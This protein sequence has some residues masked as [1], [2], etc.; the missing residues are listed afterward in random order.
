MKIIKTNKITALFMGRTDK[1]T[2]LWFPIQKMTWTHQNGEYLDCVTVFT[3][4]ARKLEQLHPEQ[5]NI[6][7]FG[8]LGQVIKSRDIYSC[9]WSNRMPVNQEP[10]PKIL[11]CLGLERDSSVDPVQYVARSGGYRHGDNRDIFPQVQADARGNYNF[12]F[13][14]V[15]S[16]SF[17]TINRPELNCI[18]T[19]EIVTPTLIE[20]KLELYCQGYNIG[21]APPYIR[22]LYKKYRDSLAISV[23]QINFQVPFEYQFLLLATLNQKTG[24]PL[25]EFE[26]QPFDE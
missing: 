4:G 9:P 26:Y 21:S 15:D 6:V 14:N 18:R 19:G 16:Y 13:R 17:A 12:I 5:P 3:N 1:A 10:D 25:N 23:Y 11:E 22:E 2:G 7:T 8:S 24:I 20:G